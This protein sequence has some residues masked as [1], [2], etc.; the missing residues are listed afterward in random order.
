MLAQY[1]H[2][3]G[4]AG[5]R[6]HSSDGGELPQGFGSPDLVR[7]TSERER[8]VSGGVCNCRGGRCSTFVLRFLH[9]SQ[10][11]AVRFLRTFWRAFLGAGGG[12]ALSA[13]FCRA[14]MAAGWM[15][16]MRKGEKGGMEKCES[17]GRR[18]RRCQCGEAH[19]E[20][21]C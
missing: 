14:G 3:P 7:R 9:R 20:V 15:D 17:R 1:W 4:T 21:A 11:T 2:G 8:S 10:L 6:E 18:R 16:P 13:V 19:A 5:K 12:G